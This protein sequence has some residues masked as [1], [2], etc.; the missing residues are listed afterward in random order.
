MSDDCVSDSRSEN[1]ESKPRF[2]EN[3][4]LIQDIFLSEVLR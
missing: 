2:F 3:L 1:R 4:E